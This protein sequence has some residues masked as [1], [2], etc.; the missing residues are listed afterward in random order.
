LSN[1]NVKSASDFYQCCK[2]HVHT[3]Q[4]HNLFNRGQ[5][6]SKQTVSSQNCPGACTLI[7]LTVAWK[8][9]VPEIL[10][11]IYNSSII[12]SKIAQ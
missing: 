6:H 9:I 2:L 3:R 7:D 11:V 8:G 10:I 4:I 1:N 12:F 5:I